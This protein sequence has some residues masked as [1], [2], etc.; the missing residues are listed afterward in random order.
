MMMVM[1]MLITL[2]GYDPAIGD[3]N[4]YPLRNSHVHGT[5]VAGNVSAVT[6]NGIGLASIGY[7]VKLMGVNANNNPDEPWIYYS[8]R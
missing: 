8:C 7:S 6:N 4:P 1:V 3:N 2:V 5:K